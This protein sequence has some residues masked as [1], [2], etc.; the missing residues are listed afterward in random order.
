MCGQT[1][2]FGAR[3]AAVEAF[4]LDT[5]WASWK[6][7]RRFSKTKYWSSGSI[8]TVIVGG[9]LGSASRR[10]RMG[11]LDEGGKGWVLTR[12][13]LQGG[14]LALCSSFID[15]TGTRIQMN[16]GGPQLKSVLIGRGRAGDRGPSTRNDRGE[17]AAIAKIPT[18]IRD[19][20]RVLGLFTCYCGLSSWGTVGPT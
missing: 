20:T 8:L 12:A 18:G 2:A 7:S 14:G 15:V 6:E 10:Q 13:R 4:P 5:G 11:R 1:S 3:E 9:D 19:W 16:V 17:E